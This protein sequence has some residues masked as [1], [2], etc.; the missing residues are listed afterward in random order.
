[1]LLEIG[2]CA[3]VFKLVRQELT[4][5]GASSSAT[6]EDLLSLSKHDRLVDLMGEKFASVI[7]LCLKS[8]ASV[9]GVPEGTEIKDDLKQ[10]VEVLQNAAE[11]IIGPITRYRI[12]ECAAR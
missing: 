10:V 5:P 8:S 11:A 6:L 3:P 1:V 2:F 7:E 12:N 4:R 9:F